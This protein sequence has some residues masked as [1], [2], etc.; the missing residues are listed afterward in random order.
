MLRKGNILNAN[1][2]A[3]VVPSFREEQLTL[4]MAKACKYPVLNS[5]KEQQN[6]LMCHSKS[7][8]YATERRNF[9]H[10]Q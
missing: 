9:N 3:R 2:K 7:F 1:E 5:L 6:L 4:G 8:K 10:V